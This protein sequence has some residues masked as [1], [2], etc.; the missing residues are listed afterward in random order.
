MILLATNRKWYFCLPENYWPIT[1]HP[2]VEV[3][4]PYHRNTIFAMID[5][6]PNID[7]LN[8][9]LIK[10]QLHGGLSNTFTD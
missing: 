7:S 2:K 4:V 8:K 10:G 1:T 6:K 9:R 5:G 3:L